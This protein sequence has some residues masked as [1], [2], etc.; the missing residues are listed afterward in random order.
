MIKKKDDITLGIPLIRRYY[1]YMVLEFIRKTFFKFT[2]VGGVSQGFLEDEN[3]QFEE[4][5]KDSIKLYE[6]TGDIQIYCRDK[7]KILKKSL[8]LDKKIHGISC[9][10]SGAR[11]FYIKDRVYITG[12]KD[13]IQEYKIFLFYSIKENKI[14]RLADMNKPRSY[15]TMVYH[16]NLKSI[17][18]FGGENNKTCEMFDFFLNSWTEIPELC[19]PRANIS[20]F[21]DKLGTFA[22]AF[23]GTEGPISNSKNTDIIELLDLVDMNHGWALV[24]YYNKA[25]VDLKFSHTGIYPFTDDKILIYGASESRKFKI[26]CC[27]WR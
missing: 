7:R 9:F 16:E 20:I 27:I 5:I 1:S 13:C 6:G 24:D 23:C 26:N 22:Y 8:I 3:Q 15:H 25:N 2:S 17:A 21:I 18:V 4:I 11:T 12:G 14:Y 10:P 19:V